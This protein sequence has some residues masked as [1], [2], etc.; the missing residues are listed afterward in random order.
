M[1]LLQAA[2]PAPLPPSTF[3]IFRPPWPGMQP[4]DTSASEASRLLRLHG[5]EHHLPPFESARAA[6]HAAWC[7]CAKRSL[8]LGS[9]DLPAPYPSHRATE[10]VQA[11]SPGSSWCGAPLGEINGRRHGG[12][13]CRVASLKLADMGWRGLK[14]PTVPAGGSPRKRLVRIS[15]RCKS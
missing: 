1:A 3:H 14:K 15:G 2:G 13:S 9:G 4:K 12:V 7:L 8:M 10:L 6:R 5:A 11:L